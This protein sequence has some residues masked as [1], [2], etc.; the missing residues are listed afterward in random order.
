VFHI[1]Q[2]PCLVAND[3]VLISMK[4]AQQVQFTLQGLDFREL[5][6]SGYLLISFMTRQIAER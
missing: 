3:F 2:H 1:V 5:W 4:P 6:M